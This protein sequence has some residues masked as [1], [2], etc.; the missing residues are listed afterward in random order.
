MVDPRK[1]IFDAVRALCPA[2]VFNKPENIS[3]LH[4]LLDALGA[5]RE[6]QKAHALVND[7]A[8]YQGM[9]AV[10][11]PL[12][13]TQVK[14]IQ[15]LLAAA[16]HWSVGWMAYALATAW[17]E[18]RLMPI[19]EKGNGDGPDADQFD[20]YLQKYDTGKLAAALGNTPAADG[21][22][23]KYAGRG[24]VQLTGKANYEKAGKF[25]GLDLLGN[26]DLALIPENAVRILVWGMEGGEFTRR[27]LADFIG[28]LGTPESFRHSRTII[29]G[30][31]KAVKIADYAEG[32]QKALI[33]GGW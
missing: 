6:G 13:E 1:P 32:F 31:D 8:F 33:A 2:G 23:V 27:K 26:P 22:G 16:P 20:D 18:C 14:T 30:T 7:G 12:N 19:R 17:H 21:D 3:A 11:G 5:P 15:A 10:T 25:L 29:N 28:E 9:R 4:N 24:L